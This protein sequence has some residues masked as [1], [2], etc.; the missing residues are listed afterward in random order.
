M[1]MI[2]LTDAGMKKGRKQWRGC[3]PIR[4]RPASRQ[5]AGRLLL[6]VQLGEGGHQHLGYRLQ[7]GCVPF[8]VDVH[9]WVLCIGRLRG[10][11]L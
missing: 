11:A 5:P 10:V 6:A 8:E 1:P 2:H 4:V 9:L 7:P 3:Q